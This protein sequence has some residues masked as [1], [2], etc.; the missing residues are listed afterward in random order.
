MEAVHRRTDGTFVVAPQTPDIRL[1]AEGTSLSV[2][3]QSIDAV[4]PDRG[5]G[6]VAIRAVAAAG[7]DGVVINH[8]E[9]P[10][11][12]ADVEAFVAGCASFDLESIV[13]VD[14]VEVGRAVLTLDPDCLLFEAPSDVATGR[15]MTRQHPE[16][17][18][19]FVSMVESESPRTRVLLGGGIS[20]AADVGDAFD[21]GAD[22]AGAASAFVD[23]ADPEAWLSSIAAALV[24]E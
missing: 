20:S 17:V 7:A 21:L 1:L 4:E 15:A 12:L 19:A 8:P 5:N 14:S 16:R 24:A 6:Q 2:V 23:A 3:A 18:E 22:A 13:C 10:D 9:S 11:T